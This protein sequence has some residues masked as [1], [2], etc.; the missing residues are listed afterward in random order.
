MK[1][2]QSYSWHCIMLFILLDHT[3]HHQVLGCHLWRNHGR[4]RCI[5][6]DK[7]HHHNDCRL[8]L[9]GKHTNEL[10]GLFGMRPRLERSVQL[11]RYHATMHY[12]SLDNLYIPCQIKSKPPSNSILQWTPAIWNFRAF[13]SKIE[14]KR[15]EFLRRLFAKISSCLSSFVYDFFW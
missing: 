8:G 1:N 13:S 9:I 6:D 2:Y 7:I 3:C 12:R 4:L 14:Q 11:V 10:R 5:R 15:F